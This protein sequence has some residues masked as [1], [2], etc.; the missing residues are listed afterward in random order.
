MTEIRD[1]AGMTDAQLMEFLTG[2]MPGSIWHEA[3]KAHLQVRMQQKMLDTATRT[4]A[5]AKRLERATW[6]ILLTTLVQLGL[7]I[8]QMVRGH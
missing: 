8:V 2:N 4:E 1:L 6:V 7:F 3:A 5:S